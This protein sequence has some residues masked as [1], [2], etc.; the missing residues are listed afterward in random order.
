MKDALTPKA[1]VAAQE[2]EFGY[3]KKSPT[4]RN[5]GSGKVATGDEREVPVA[6]AKDERAPTDDS[7]PVTQPSRKPS[8]RR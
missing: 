6:R 7:R 3:A 8:V 2:T 1:I 4:V 5:P